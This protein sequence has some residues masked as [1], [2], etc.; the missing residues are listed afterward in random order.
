MQKNKESKKEL[1]IKIIERLD[2]ESKIRLIYFYTISIC[3]N[4]KKK[5]E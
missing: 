2:D 3:I 1:L 4:L 5:R